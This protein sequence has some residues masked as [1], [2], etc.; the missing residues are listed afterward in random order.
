MLR[1]LVIGLVVLVAVMF[2]APRLPPPDTAT[3]LRTPRPLPP[4]T[5]TDQA[6]RPFSDTDMQGR[7]ALLFVG[8]TRCS[9]V[10]ARTLGILSETRRTLTQRLGDRAPRIVFVSVDARRDTPAAVGAYVARFDPAFI[11]LA[12]HADADL[13]ALTQTLGGAERRGSGGESDA[14]EDATVY[15]TDPQARLIALFA[16]APAAATLVSD[17]LRI[18]ARALRTARS[19]SAPPPATP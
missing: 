2:M 17:Y 15:V 9:N 16:A 7:F 6:G 11:G 19:A 8:S 13:A 5:L 3:E 10:C 4:F 1:I 14:V 18:R 12:A